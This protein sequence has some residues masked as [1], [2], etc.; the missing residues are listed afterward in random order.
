[1]DETSLAGLQ[2]WSVVWS[3]GHWQDIYTLRLAHK[4]CCMTEQT[5]TAIILAPAKTLHRVA[6]PAFTHTHKVSRV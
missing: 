2:V 1:M 3:A 4:S 6:H 5:D